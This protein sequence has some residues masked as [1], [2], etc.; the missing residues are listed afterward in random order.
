[1]NKESW[2]P[3]DLHGAFAKGYI[4]PERCAEIMR[5]GEI[6][7][8]NRRRVIN[9]STAERHALWLAAIEDGW[10][11]RYNNEGY[12]T[13]R[14]YFLREAITEALQHESKTA[15][16]LQSVQPVSALWMVETPPEPLDF[17]LGVYGFVRVTVGIL[18][19]AGATGKSFFALQLAIDIATGANLLGMGLTTGRVAY[20]SL[21]DHQNIVHHRTFA[22]GQHLDPTARARLHP[23]NLSILPCVGTR[24]DVEVEEAEIIARYR[25]YRLIIVDTLSKA[26]SYEENS[27][28][29]MSRLLVILDRI[30]RDTGAGV[31]FLHHVAKNADG[32]SQHAAR[33]ASAITD[34]ARW[35]GYVQRLSVEDAEHAQTADGEDIE[36]QNAWKYICFNC[37][38]P[39]YTQPTD[40]CWFSREEGT[41][42]LLPT[43]LQEKTDPEGDERAA[44]A[45]RL[46]KG[47]KRGNSKPTPPPTPGAT[48]G[49]SY[50]AGKNGDS[51]TDR[52]QSMDEVVHGIFTEEPGDDDDA[53]F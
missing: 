7:V 33:G 2:K 4:T 23:E 52:H 8:R 1:M 15:A 44:A 19:A 35:A 53:I 48:M 38:K 21:E 16:G 26:H 28:S 10:I 50:Y 43:K 24:V 41:G 42:V 46:I 22:I 31:L 39:N 40:P 27:N 13:E 32:K 18:T 3:L 12:D 11:G 45:K 20:L 37:A 14:E 30:A 36:S 34:N 9:T 49:N 25:G 5:M 17:I 47:K 6:A 29:E 51:L